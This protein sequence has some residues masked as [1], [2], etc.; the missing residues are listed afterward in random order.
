MFFLPAIAGERNRISKNAYN[1]NGETVHYQEVRRLEQIVINGGTPLQGSVRIHG[2]K[3]AVLPILAAT[4]LADGVHTVKNCPRLSDVSITEEILKSLGAKTVRREDALVVDATGETGSFIPEKLMR[5]LRS[6]VVFM[7]AVLAKTGRVKISAPGGCELGP[8]PIDLHLKALSLL[9]AEIYEEHGYLE[10]YAKRLTGCHIHLDFPSV[11]A[12]E[13]VMLAGVLAEGETVITNA[14][15]DPEICDLANFLNACG[16]RV[17]GAGTSSIRIEGVRT[18]HPASYTVMPDRIAATT[19]LCAAAATG[20]EVTVT[21][22]EPEHISA[23]LSVLSDCG[24]DITCGKNTVHLKAPEKLSACGAIRTMPYPGFPTDAQSLMLATLCVARGTGL[25]TETIFESRFKPVPELSRMGAKISVS[26]RV[27][28]I[29]GVD[30]LWGAE[31]CAEDLRGGAALVIAGLC[32]RGKTVIHNPC[33]LDR[34][35]EALEENLAALGADIKR[36]R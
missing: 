36:Y 7:G 16:A 19:Y 34:G 26:D 3:N 23:V 22:M 6:S 27:A 14:A 12:T 15:R 5:K 20:G 1:D 25:I 28:V 11:G 10:H 13:N 33:F 4:V 31:V 32:A 18:L 29:R 9:G 2:A 17:S 35:Y 8:R 24:C 30:A 21:H